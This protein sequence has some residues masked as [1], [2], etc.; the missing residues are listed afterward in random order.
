MIR[1]ATFLLATL[2]VAAAADGAPASS[3]RFE[4]ED[5]EAMNRFHDLGG[6]PIIRKACD[7]ASGGVAIEGLDLDGEYLEF[8]LE[9]FEPWCFTD[10]L[11]CAGALD[12]NWEFRVE[13][14]N[15]EE[16]QP[17]A[18]DWVPSVVGRGIG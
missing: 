10:S 11:R 7:D 17:G 1:S 5:A 18:R 12:G 8:D 15:A 13:F 2:L 4:A 6:I 16:G 14:I 9:L 3:L